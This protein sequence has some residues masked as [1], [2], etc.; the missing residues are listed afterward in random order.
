MVPRTHHQN[1]LIIFTTNMT[2]TAADQPPVQYQIFQLSEEASLPQHLIKKSKDKMLTFVLFWINH[3]YFSSY[4]PERF[5]S[6]SK[7]S[8]RQNIYSN[9]EDFQQKRN[10]VS[11]GTKRLNF[12]S[13]KQQENSQNGRGRPFSSYQKQGNNRRNEGNISRPSSSNR[14]IFKHFEQ[15]LQIMYYLVQWD[16]AILFMIFVILGLETP[17]LSMVFIMN[18]LKRRS[19]GSLM[20]GKEYQWSW[21]PYLQRHC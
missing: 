18:L 14:F 8:G 2:T 13:Q 11:F 17:T 4:G 6:R 19:T 9:S 3:L 15:N 12:N 20:R 7:Y 5:T 1:F 16:S 10:N 21:Q